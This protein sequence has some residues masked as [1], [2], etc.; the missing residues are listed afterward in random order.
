MVHVPRIDIRSRCEKQ[1]DNGARCCKMEWHL[2]IASTFIHARWIL[3]D[4]ASEEVGTIEVC[5]RASIGDS[6]GCDQ[7]VGGGA[8]RRVERVKSARPPI[9]APVRVGTEVEQHVYHLRI[10]GEGDY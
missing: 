9:A 7:P 4:Q 3:G 6:A 8:R 10:F 1:I 5:R 2:P